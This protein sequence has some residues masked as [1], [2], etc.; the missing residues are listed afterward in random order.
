MSSLFKFSTASSMD[1]FFKKFAISIFLCEDLILRKQKRKHVNKKVDMLL[2]LEQREEISP[3][4]TYIFLQGDLCMEK[5][6]GLNPSLF[7]LKMEMF[8]LLACK[9]Y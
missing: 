5:L 9:E 1:E 3:M 4:H 7:I 8:K 2:K 6:H